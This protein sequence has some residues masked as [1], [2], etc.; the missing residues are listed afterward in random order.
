VVAR[1][2]LATNRRDVVLVEQPAQVLVAVG[3][4]V[5]TPARPPVSRPTPISVKIRE[6]IPVTEIA[7][8]VGHSRKSLDTYAHVLID[9]S[10]K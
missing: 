7:A 3:D 5:A 4:E 1:L 9:E 2:R 8:N 6:G 10:G